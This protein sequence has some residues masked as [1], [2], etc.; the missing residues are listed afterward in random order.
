MISLLLINTSLHDNHNRAYES[1]TTQTARRLDGGT[2]QRRPQNT[3]LRAINR[4]TLALISG[5]D[6]ADV[7]PVS[8]TVGEEGPATR[9][10][11][12]WREMRDLARSVFHVYFTNNDCDED[13]IAQLKQS[14]A[15]KKSSLLKKINGTMP[16]L[17][18]LIN[19]SDAPNIVK[20]LALFFEA[21]LRGMAQVRM[22]TR[23]REYA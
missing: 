6:D 15:S 13:G 3:G 1:G 16:W 4:D 23:E 19:G 7:T 9:Q 12:E 18:E 22:R 21:S 8:K 10:T 2:F 14:D 20:A 11:K 5:T 17:P